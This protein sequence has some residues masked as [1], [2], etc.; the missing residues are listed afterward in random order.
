M[1]AKARV[2]SYLRFSDPKQAA[3]GS[4]D[5]QM[6][7]ASR[8]AADNEMELDASLSLRDEGLSAYHQRHVKQ[9][10]LGVF[11]RAIEDGQVPAGSVLIVEGLDRL[12]RAEP[13]QAQAQLAQIVNAG[14]TVVTASDG[15][16]Y[17]RERLKAQPMDLV[18][19][20]LVMIRAHEE[21][22]TKSKRVKAAIRRQ[23][24][25]W[26]AG[27]WRAPIRVGKDPQWVREVG[28]KFELIPE[29]AAAIRLVVDMYKKGHG[30]VH[31]LRHLHGR[32][33]AITDAGLPGASQLYKLLANP[34]L[35]G[36]K[37]VKLDG[38][39][40]RLQGYYPAVLTSAEFA[41]LRNLAA[42]RGR[43]K[44]KGEIPGVVTGLGITYCGYCG[45]AIVA[46]NIMGRR[47]MANGLPY[48]GHRRLHCVTYSSSAGC[49]VSGSC[50]VAP[51]EHALMHYCSD[52][53]NLT[54]LLEGD[55]GVTAATAQL[56]SARQWVAKLE[57][58]IQRFTDALLL[59]DGEAPIAVL[60][61]VRE[62]ESQVVSERRNVN[63]LE[64]K[65]TASVS[66]VAPVSANTWR[67]LVQ[68]VASLS[69]D[70]R[71]TARQLVADTFSKIVVYQAGFR[72]DID[73]GSI[74]LLLFAKRGTIRTLHIDRRTGEWRAAQEH[75][76]AENT[77]PFGL[78]NA[79]PA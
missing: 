47:R 40:F 59:D 13:I 29:R 55:V 27:T 15:R 70:A 62:L 61:R 38:E 1:A 44:G 43:R 67:D 4:V 45:A 35:I 60:R 37:T 7:Y 72:P 74:G 54:R 5:R 73:N 6:E 48:P 58:Q 51:V 30:A 79:E 3:G 52:Q 11:L 32:G 39:H 69:Y 22:D 24:Q 16:Q 20:L 57:A 77:L 75:D 21:S 46:Q 34:M 71:M 64:Q 31:T 68:G 28:G 63:V 36:E 33:L 10:A 9:G 41:D 2:Y 23:C 78:G 53:M 19:S 49:K 56:A 50:S 12:S 26:I 42:Q 76:L 8:W 18:Y 65:L 17:N 14:I 25:G 66:N